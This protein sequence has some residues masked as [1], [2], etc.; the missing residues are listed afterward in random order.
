MF[1]KNLLTI[2]IIFALFGLYIPALAQDTKFPDYSYEFLGADKY[3]NFNRKMFR[4]NQ[5]LNKYVIRP[6]HIVWVSILPQY[7]MDRI[8]GISNNIEYPIRLV[9]SLVQRDFKNSADETKRFLINTTI[10]L[11]GMFDPA[12]HILHVEQSKENMDQAL[13]KCKIKSG[14]YIVA[15]VISFTTI[16]GLFGRALDVAL[17]PSSYIGSPI[18]AA[19]KA[20]LTIN[21]TSYIQPLLKMVESNY[22]DP[23]EIA[24]KAFGIDSYIKKYNYDRV[25]V[26]SKLRVEPANKSKV[27]MEVS[28][29]IFETEPE[30]KENLAY[31]KIPDTEIVSLEQTSLTPDII[32]NDYNPQSPVVDSMR[33]ALFSIPGIDKSI[34]NELS[35]WNR[36]FNNRLKTSEINLSQGRNNYKF[37][38]LLQKDKNS[39]L[40]IIYPSIGEGIS[41]GHS[42]VI[43]KLFYD[44]GYSI[45]IQGS[46]FQWEFVESMPADYRPGIPSN[47]AD[48]MIMATSKIMAKLGA[49]YNMPFENKVIIGTSF[50]ALT[51]LCVGAKEA[52][53]NT[54]GKVNYIAISPPYDL[55]YAMNQVDKISEIPYNSSDDIKQ[56]VAIVSAKI[57][58]LYQSKKDINFEVNNLPFTEEEANLITGFIMHQKL[59]DLIFVI[60]NTPT[61]KKSDFYTLANSINYKDYTEKYLFKNVS[62]NKLKDDNWF[63]LSDIAMFLATHKNYKIYHSMTD[64]LTNKSQ[65]KNL[66]LLTGN[67]TVLI[68]NGAHL[69]FLYRSE[70]IEDLKA[71]ILDFKTNSQL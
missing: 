26:M 49:K 18:L 9:S 65:L 29:K 46:P 50:G 43:G 30:I 31:N 34:W 11:G 33:T 58:K 66:K 55:V 1:K 47:D 22:A 41:S 32:L 17:N 27:Q 71:T 23:Y 15:P 57:V 16:R 68:D 8:I 35:L 56:N 59:S 3:E 63:S 64:Y 39:P 21:R 62:D 45:V 5:R 48:A 69:G 60:E 70:F 37:R 54:L 24:K 36:T 42:V 53:H 4:F 19:V 20:G 52:E 40:A 10:G 6:V 51:S 13:E 67:K 12:K 14:P 61:N 7:G 25:E 28:A 44:A 2:T 38:Y